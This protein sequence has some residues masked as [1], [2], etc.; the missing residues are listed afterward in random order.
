MKP[1]QLFIILGIFI[2]SVIIN[3]VR[4]MHLKKL[5]KKH[6]KHEIHHKHE[7]HHKHDS[8][9]H[10]THHKHKEHHN[11]HDS[12]EKNR[13]QVIYYTK[14]APLTN[15]EPDVVNAVPV[16]SSNLY[17]LSNNQVIS[18]PYGPHT[19]LTTEHVSSGGNHYTTNTSSI[20]YSSGYSYGHWQKI[21]MR[22]HKHH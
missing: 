6:H 12:N 1:Y 8:H 10:D 22:K 19:P 9:K 20:P 7:S 15:V 13:K 3:Q 14:Y 17:S 5:N 21:P 11:K 2:L 4:S 16:S 18:T